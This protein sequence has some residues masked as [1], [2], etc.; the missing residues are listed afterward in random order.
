[1]YIIFTI[2]TVL[3]AESDHLKIFFYLK[4]LPK[5]KPKTNDKELLRGRKCFVSSYARYV[6]APCGNYLAFAIL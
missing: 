3:C 6:T 5:L 2:S 1:M 4:T